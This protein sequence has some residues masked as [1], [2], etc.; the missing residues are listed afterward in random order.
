[1]SYCEMEGEIALEVGMDDWKIVA[2]GCVGRI[3]GLHTA[4]KTENEII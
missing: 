4:I 3:D 2:L 1:M